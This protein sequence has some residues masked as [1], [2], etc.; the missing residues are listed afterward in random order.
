MNKEQAKKER[1][2]LADWLD[3]CFKDFSLYDPD[4][5]IYGCTE[6]QSKLMAGI[7]KT[8]KQEPP[9]HPKPDNTKYNYVVQ[10]YKGIK[11]QLIQRKDYL[12]KDAKRFLILPHTHTGLTNQ[13]VW[14]PN[15]HLMEDGT[16]LPG[17]N[18]DY[19]FRRAQ[20]QLQLASYTH[21]IPGIKGD[22][23]D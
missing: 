21:R 14:I 5:G 12:Y 9:V 18:I 20:R 13:N 22:N 8:L 15:K 3:E 16:I 11:L 10:V 17:E 4:V 23:N 19:V 6:Y 1:L 7:L 2:E